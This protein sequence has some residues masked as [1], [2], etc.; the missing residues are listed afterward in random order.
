VL[1]ETILAPDV[2]D[3][4]QR[5]ADIPRGDSLG[6]GEINEQTAGMRREGRQPR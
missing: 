1:V 2:A 6:A 3:Y 5:F 4:P